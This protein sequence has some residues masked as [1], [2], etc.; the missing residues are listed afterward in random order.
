MMKKRKFLYLIVGLIILSMIIGY[1]YMYKEHRN[2]S[3]EKA[4][5][6]TTAEVLIKEYIND[7]E[8]NI[9]RYL[10]KIIQLKGTITEVD[11]ES[12]TL[13]KVIVCYADSITLSSVE[14]NSSVIVKGRNIGFDELLELI[15][16]DQVTIIN[17]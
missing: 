13:N 9:N 4:E 14:N 1:N 17:N 2:I 15:K 11:K 8:T 12:F 6:N 10:D 5:F 16:L 3:T 7:L